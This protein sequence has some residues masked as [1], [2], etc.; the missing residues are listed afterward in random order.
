ML[1]IFQV[2]SDTNIGGAGRYLLNYLKYFDRKKFQVTVVMPEGSLLRE[3]VSE[4]SDVTVVQAP[5]MADKS[6]DRRCA[7]FLTR[8][9]KEAKPDILHTHASL[10]ARI[11]AKRAGVGKI[12][13]TRHCI[14]EQG[15]RLKTVLGSAVNNYLC[16]VYIAVSDAVKKNLLDSGVK[17]EKIRVVANGVEPVR[18]IPLDEINKIKE[19]LGIK[20][21]EIVFGVFARVEKI[22]GHRYFIK[23]ASRIIKE[24]Y[25]AR[26]LVVGD[27]SELESIK[28]LAKN[29]GVSDNVIF[30]GY[31]KDTTSLLNVV[32]VNVIS[33]HSEAMSLAILEAMSLGKPS[34]ATK[35]GGNPQVIKNNVNGILVNVAD[36][37]SLAEAMIKILED[38]TLYKNLSE[39]AVDEYRRMYT[40]VTMVTN[41]EKIYLEAE[42]NDR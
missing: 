11:A 4:Y 6:Y 8:L 21:F 29:A 27:G 17:P 33:S 31:V 40:A 14:E 3:F 37:S 24:G 13:S 28:E 32:D 15:S 30:T 10:S 9:F 12:I 23:A 39:N 16:D 35:V 25:K 38:E 1:K 19:E 2:V 36:S 7:S 26:F 20:R 34:I 42:G 18:A 41:L 5:Y 22:K